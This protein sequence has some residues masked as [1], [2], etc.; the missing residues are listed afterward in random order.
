VSLVRLAQKGNLL[1]QQQAVMLVRC[2]VDAW[3][4]KCFV[5]NPW[6]NY[7][8]EIDKKIA[9]CVNRYRYT[10]SFYGYVFKT[11]YYAARSLQRVYSLDREI[12]PGKTLSENLVRDA[13]TGEIRLYRRSDHTDTVP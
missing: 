3:I 9:G 11:L 13:E 4:E 6:S 1:A 5:L 2:T 8:E 10:G 12:Y 7:G